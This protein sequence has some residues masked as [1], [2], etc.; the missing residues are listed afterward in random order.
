MKWF[1]NLKI[2]GKMLIAFGTIIAMITVLS[3][4][5]ITELRGVAGSYKYTIE[6]PKEAER[7]LRLFQYSTSELRRMTTLM[8]LFTSAND[9]ARIDDYSKDAIAAFDRGMQ[10]LKDLEIAVID[11]TRLEKEV[12]DAVLGATY[13][14]QDTFIEYKS[15]VLDPVT[16]AARAGNYDE[17]MAYIADGTSLAADLSEM[18][19]FIAGL[20][21][22]DAKDYVNDADKQADRSVMIFLAIAIGVAFIAVI[23]SFVMAALFSNGMKMITQFMMRA[24]K[25]GDISFTEN[26]KTEAAKEQAT[27]EIGMLKTGAMGFIQHITCIS[28][29]LEMIANGDLTTN[30]DVLSDDDVMGQT[31]L[32][33][34]KSLN[35]MFTD[36]NAS[37]LMVANK[38]SLVESGAKQIAATTQNIAEGAQTLAKGSTDQAASVQE[39]SSALKMVEEKTGANAQIADKASK[40]ADSV[41]VNAEKGNQQME[42]MISAVRDIAEANQSIQS[43]MNTIDS[44]ASQTNLLSLNAA[45]EAA[46]AGEH[47]RG[48]AVV[49]DEVR[50]LAAQSAEAAQKTSMIIKTSIEKSQLGTQIVDATAE[51][52]KEIVTG[53]NESS[54][55]IKSIASAS[56]EQ[57]T[58]IS[59]IK[60]G[61]DQV[62]DIVEQNSAT[63]EES[64]AAA[65]ESAASA[66]DSIEAAEELMSQADILK[67][68]LSSFKLN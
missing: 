3:I 63:A 40:L 30:L 52:F 55:L 25:T 60:H 9:P 42:D 44:I 18:A 31:L 14:L 32:K 59:K 17:V 56:E 26:E 38:A 53:L 22:S 8:A 7:Q 41:I 16:A 2:R 57:A 24:G 27:D 48:F 68:L 47:G 5:A 43:I 11:S 10:N 4:I 62:S 50:I 20:A 51:S 35:N 61:I 19:S 65:E 12:F 33:T 66:T 45:I 37:A 29:E 64:A 34:V 39:L 15:K 6:M 28:E 21:E 67:K 23:I 49:A 13:Q 1:Y 36:I 46:R 54:S 58:N